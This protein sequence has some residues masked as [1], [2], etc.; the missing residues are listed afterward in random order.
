M[1][2]SMAKKLSL[3]CPFDNQNLDCLKSVNFKASLS[4]FKQLSL[5]I[6]YVA[7]TAKLKL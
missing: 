4:G 6:K 2:K 3:A 7:I 1:Y 5:G